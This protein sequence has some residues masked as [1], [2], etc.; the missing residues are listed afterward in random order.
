MSPFF[1]HLAWAALA[2]CACAPN[3]PE[4]NKNGASHPNAPPKAAPGSDLEISLQPGGT[5]DAAPR[6]LRLQFRAGDAREL[7]PEAFHLIL[8]DLGAAPVPAPLPKSLAARAVP[9]Q[10]WLTGGWLVLAPTVVLEFGRTYSIVGERSVLRTLRVA[11]DDELPLVS[12]A[13]PPEG[14]SPT[15]L[16]GIWCGPEELPLMAVSALL[17]PPGIAGVLRSG[18]AAGEPSRRCLHFE[19]AA[20]PGGWNGPLLPPMLAG[21]NDAAPTARVEPHVLERDETPPPA[22]PPLSC[23]AG[24]IAFGRGCVRVEDDRLLLDTPGVPLLWSITT[25]PSVGLQRTIVSEG[26][27]LYLWPLPPASAVSLSVTTV[28]AAGAAQGGQVG[29]TTQ[30]AMPHLVIN[31]VMADPIGPEPEQEWVELYND[32]LAP[33]SLAGLRLADVGGET[34]LP[35]IVLPPGAF[36]LVVNDSYDA[37]G[38][39][40]PAPAPGC[41][42]LRMVKLGKDGLNNQ[43]EPIDLLDAGGGVVSHFP[44][45]KPKPGRS[46]ARLDPKSFSGFALSDDKASTPCAK[47]TFAKKAGP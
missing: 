10:R 25:A 38:K 30:S 3:L 1:R 11:D 35:S 28:D 8:G 12:L 42:L 17:D 6:V 14:R 23:A 40:D 4:P 46:A 36:A 13:W 5:L 9:A 15:G 37:S 2:T 7:D 18:V 16:L 29:L 34:L 41:S 43:G 26:E 21:A 24:K 31:E 22:G 45:I 44:A 47:N 39:Y 19:P 27:S 20:G 32:G 33:A